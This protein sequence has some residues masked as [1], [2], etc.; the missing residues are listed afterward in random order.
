VDYAARA[1]LQGELERLRELPGEARPDAVAR[2]FER[3]EDGA[4]KL[5]AIM[6]ALSLRAR[7]EALFRDGTY[8]P[9]ASDGGRARHVVAFAR[10]GPDGQCIV[11][12][13]RL[14]AMLGASPGELPVGR[15]TWQD[16]TVALPGGGGTYRDV[17]TGRTLRARG[18]R[19]ALADLLTHFPAAILAADARGEPLL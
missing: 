19:V 8:A 18:A 1:R 4:P 11:V 9:L 15:A 12:C 17:L 13:G 14:F 3:F 2:L 7:E 10:E 16:T 5:W 6:Q